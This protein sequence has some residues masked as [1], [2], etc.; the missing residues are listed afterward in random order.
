MERRQQ[1]VSVETNAAVRAA[2][3]T[4]AERAFAHGQS[5]EDLVR[6]MLRPILKSWID[7]NLPAIVE[8]L[9]RA[10]IEQAAQ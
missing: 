9:V 10:E 8:R 6:E 1:L 3:D 2:F 4:L 7:D 5:L